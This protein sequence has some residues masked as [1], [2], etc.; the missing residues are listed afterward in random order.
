MANDSSRVGILDGLL[1]DAGIPV[2]GISVVD[3]NATPPVVN[4]QYN[5]SATQEQRDLGAQILSQFDWRRRR[6]LTRATVVTAILNLTTLQRTAP[7][8]HLL[9]EYLRTNPTIAAQ[10]GVATAT[11]ITVDEVD[12]N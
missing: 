8:N 7:L 1:K 12:P 11:P 4:I 9:A 3:I 6:A 10:I 2:D 5:G